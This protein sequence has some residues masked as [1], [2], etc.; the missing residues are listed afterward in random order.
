M[1]G[2][3]LI[4]N[5]RRHYPQ[6]GVIVNS[7]EPEDDFWRLNL[8]VDAY[9]RKGA[10]SLKLLNTVVVGVMRKLGSLPVSASG[11]V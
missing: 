8:P 3:E 9:L 1:S 2:Y 11:F 10:Y 7:A 4:P 6:V 5:I